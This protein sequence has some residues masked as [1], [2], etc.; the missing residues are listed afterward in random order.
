MLSSTEPGSAIIAFGIPYD[1][2]VAAVNCTANVDS[3]SCSYS[4]E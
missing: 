3:K 2:P 1:S 4:S